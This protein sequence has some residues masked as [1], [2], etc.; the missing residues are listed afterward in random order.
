MIIL[1]GCSLWCCETGLNGV[2]KITE[3]CVCT[4]QYN[5]AEPCIWCYIYE[6]AFVFTVVAKKILAVSSAAPF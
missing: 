3:T 5:S 4:T 2:A 1:G 6:N